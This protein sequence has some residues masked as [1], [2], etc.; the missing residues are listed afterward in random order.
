MMMIWC[1]L[2]FLVG[3]LAGL[4]TRWIRIQFEQLHAKLDSLLGK[5]KVNVFPRS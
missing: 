2:A 3:F 5:A 1:A 4:S